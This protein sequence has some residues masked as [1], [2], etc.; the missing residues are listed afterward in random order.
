LNRHENKN[1]WD[2]DNTEDG[3]GGRFMFILPSIPSLYLMK[4]GVVIIVVVSLDEG[5][6]YATMPDWPSLAARMQR[7]SH[8]L[9]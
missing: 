2:N 3:G 6:C 8:R 4:S 9:G 1:G 5:V 7:V